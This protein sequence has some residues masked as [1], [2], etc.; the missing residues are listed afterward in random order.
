[1]IHLGAEQKLA[2]QK[3][4]KMDRFQIR[5][6]GL[7]HSPVLC[8]CVTVLVTLSVVLCFSELWYFFK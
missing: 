6:P 4:R 5:E 2:K 1:M 3:L 7:K 8:S